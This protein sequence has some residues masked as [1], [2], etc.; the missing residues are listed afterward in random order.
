MRPAPV[1]VTSVDI[2]CSNEFTVSFSCS[3]YKCICYIYMNVYSA[4][5]LVIVI[6]A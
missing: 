2:C 3:T 1:V 6:A 5:Q 4:G